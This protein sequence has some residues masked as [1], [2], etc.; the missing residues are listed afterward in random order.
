M[1]K[2]WGKIIKNNTIVQSYVFESDKDELDF[3]TL[4]NKGIEDICNR[5]DIGNPM[6][7]HDNTLNMNQINKT[8]FK[9]QHFIEEIDF[10]YFEIEY[11]EERM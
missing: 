1:F 2:L 8:S 4:L 6:W 5:F 3:E 11:F 10:D 9:K 7:L